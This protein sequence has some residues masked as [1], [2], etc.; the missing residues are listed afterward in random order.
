MRYSSIRPP[1]AFLAATALALTG[2]VAAQ[3]APEDGPVEAGIHVAKVEGLPADFVAGV[4]VSSVL[5]LEES[6][7]VF[8]DAEGD[9]AD[10]FELLA[11]AGITDVRV[12]VWN[13]PYDAEGHGYG[14]GTVDAERATTIGQR[15]TAA[16]LGVLVDFHYSD[17][18]AD[19]G[20][21]M[22][23][24]AWAAL[25]TAAKAAAVEEYTTATLEAMA[26]A[27]VDVTMVQVGNE[28]NGW[29]AGVSGW[30]GMA[31]IFSAGSAAV[32]EVFPEALVALHF[33]N[34]ET[35]GRYAGYAWELNERDVDY[36]VFA[37][38]Y[39]PFWHGSTANLT[40]VLKDVADTY[41]KQVLVAETS[42]ASTLADGDG[43]EN[44]IKPGSD[45]SAYPLGAQGQAD[46]VRDV[47]Q[48]VVD[49]GDA[50]LG[51]FYWEPAWLPVGPPEQ[52]EANRLLWEAHGSGWASSYAG[53]YDADAGEWF[54]GSAWDN[55]ALFGL[56]GRPLESLRI[57]DY[58]RTGATA[59]LEVVSVE[60]PVVT[61]AQGDELVLPAT[62]EV[63]YNDGST[64]HE[65]V[66]WDALPD[67]VELP[68]TYVV[69]GV[70][71]GG[72]ATT[73][74]VV[75]EPVNFLLNPGFEDDDVSMW[76]FAGTAG[77]LAVT[78]STADSIGNRSVNFWG[79]S[80]YTMSVSQTVTGLAP[81][82]YAVAVQ[83][84]GLSGAEVTLTATTADGAL[85]ATATLAG[86][87]AWRTATIPEVEVGEDGTMT[88]TASGELA[89]EVWGYLDAFVLTWAG[90]I[91]PEEP[92]EPLE[93]VTSLLTDPS[94]E[95]SSDAWVITGTGAEVAAVGSNA[96]HGE[97][98]VNFWADAPYAF[99][100]SQQVTGL[101]PGTY[102]V[103]AVTQG[104]DT[105]EGDSA[106]LRLV[107]SRGTE[108]V[109]LELAGWQEFRTA[110]TDS[111]VVTDG[112][113]L[114]EAVLDLSAG[115][116]GTFDQVV[117][118]RT[119]DAPVDPPVE[120]DRAVLAG[121][122]A[123]SGTARVGST[124]TVAPGS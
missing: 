51:V 124:L 39:Y 106:E 117:L 118:E 58:V 18:W 43:H 90:G 9:A 27:G 2:A 15:A 23:P 91:P 66:T 44:V 12:R 119:G 46:A 69:D 6:G 54:G 79:G 32:R 67:G 33:T 11:D 48:A 102:R 77:T 87:Q 59:P 68:G 104:G 50:G 49:V 20:K 40:A 103:S 99:S 94:F 38:S 53:E 3:A 81:G 74:T 80:D 113:L 52:V 82:T 7:V 121:T 17:F 34:P 93:P 22:A 19:P 112:E 8:R 63:R 73:A 85:D 26:D 86:W 55:Q 110:T 97:R 62:V 78:S 64:A 31:Q 24:K 5:S 57:F 16:G 122:P 37:S 70:T 107:G 47:V 84:H 101:A 41:G 83:G 25:D 108:T 36:D 123:V 98:A 35:A 89:A 29:V 120:P 88:V 60:T 42:W 1:A 71:V 10:L 92:E 115:A 61:V 95:D 72:H 13:D 45:V 30:D 75:V 14:G 105:G 76:D 28:T 21:Q 114:V 109:P 65:A 4:D 111:L 100:V 96:S 56:D 116:W